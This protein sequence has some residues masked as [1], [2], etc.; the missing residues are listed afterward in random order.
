MP[1]NEVCDGLLKCFG[2]SDSLLSALESHVSR[3][4]EGCEALTPCGGLC[5]CVR[6][7]GLQFR[8]EADEPRGAE[9]VL[10][11]I[12][13]HRQWPEDI[14]RQHIGARGRDVPLLDEVAF[15][16]LA[17]AP[18]EPGP[19]QLAD[20]VVDALAGQPEPRS[21]FRCRR[22]LAGEGHDARP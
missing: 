15:P 11:P 20:V 5:E 2:E 14:R 16:E 6:D 9:R 22:R 21:Q 3:D 19:R 8:G 17:R 12:S 10:G 4:R 18:Q 7:V 13:G 1:A